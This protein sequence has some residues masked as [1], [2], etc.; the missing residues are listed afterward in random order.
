MAKEIDKQV[1][2]AAAKE[3]VAGKKSDALAKY[4]DFAIVE[5]TLEGASN[6]DPGRKARKAIFLTEDS[7]KEERKTLKKRIELWKT[8]LAE[9]DDIADMVGQCQERSEAAS[10]LLGK[11]VTKGLEAT[12]NL[13]R[14]YRSM[15]L[16]FKNT[17]ADKIPNISILNAELDQLKDLDNTTFFDT[18]AAEL[19]QRYDRLDLREHYSMLVIPG[20]LG[21]NTVV[22]KW[23]KMAYKNKALMV[24]DFRN[25][26]TGEDTLEL[27]EA[28][29]LTG[30]DGYRANTI[31]TCNWLV[32]REQFE[33]F[34]EEDALYVPPSAALAGT[35]YKTLM[36]QPAA[37]KTHGG[38]SEVA[39]TRYP[40][41]KSELSE[42]ERAGLVPM[43]NE[44]SKV[45][46]FSAKTL[47][48]GDNIGLQTYSVV[49]VFDYVGKVL[50]DFLNRRSFENWNSTLERDLR[51]QIASFLDTISG[52]GKLIK[53][54][55]IK[56]IAQDKKV[57][58]RIY[59]DIH[60]TPYFPAKSFVI[61]LDGTRGNSADEWDIE[62]DNA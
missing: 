37:G 11:N 26:D 2:G 49:R 42:L 34:G 10:D 60:L 57:K 9:T 46:A 25:L 30:G 35:I 48:N 45:M 18:V 8:L 22:E 5:T 54:F 39:G 23:A 4:G 53:D 6:M 36:S 61:R 44:W 16:F 58:D 51:R 27:F 3:K 7:K 40:L 62:I 38:L 50:V 41:R 43:I 29:N 1:Q 32:G 28:E 55:T 33:E 24:T 47:F 21:S 17:E 52:P 14:S 56:R 31:M 13:E 20:Y 15:A 59:V 19:K 12:K